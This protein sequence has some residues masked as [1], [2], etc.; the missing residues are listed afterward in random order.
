MSAIMNRPSWSFEG[1][2]V[3]AVGKATPNSHIIKLVL[4]NVAGE[5]TNDFPMD[6]WGRAELLEE[7]VPGTL[8]SASGTMRSST[9]K[10]QYDDSIRTSFDNRVESITVKAAA[11]KKAAAVVTA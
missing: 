4:R 11:T 10:S 6:V 8:V 5:Y 1:F 2:V 7:L 9:Y 3:S